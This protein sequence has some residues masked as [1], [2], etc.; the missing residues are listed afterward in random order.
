MRPASILTAEGMA[1]SAKRN[2]SNQA[3][4]QAGNGPACRIATRRAAA[5]RGRQR[6]GIRGRPGGWQPAQQEVP[7]VGKHGEAALVDGKRACLLLQPILN[8]AFAAFVFL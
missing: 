2:S 5:A 8:R 4:S 7:M 3:G 6:F 1:A